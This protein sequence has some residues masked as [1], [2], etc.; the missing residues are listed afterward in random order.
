MKHFKVLISLIAIAFAFAACGD[1]SS[2]NDDLPAL[3][4]ENLKTTE[5]IIKTVDMIVANAITPV[6]S[7]NAGNI[8]FAGGQNDDVNYVSDDGKVKI[9]GKLNNMVIVFTDYAANITEEDRSKHLV[10][11]L[12]GTFSIKKSNENEQ[13][14]IVRK[15]ILD[16][17]YD[18]VDHT[19]GIN[20][21][22]TEDYSKMDDEGNL[23]YT[24]EG[25]ITFDGT[26]Y[27]Y[28]KKDKKI[29]KN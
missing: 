4:G 19:L 12:S 29:L 8:L 10:K 2:S 28:K 7:K 21:T 1:D 27:S 23:P 9:T 5:T 11:N 20:C 6:K 22:Q 25:S 26:E 24:I 16:M 13:S 15:G 17:N 14:I 3:S 18:S